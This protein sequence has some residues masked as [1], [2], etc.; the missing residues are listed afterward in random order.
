[1]PDGPI[2]TP[3]EERL[4]RLL[5]E[6]GTPEAAGANLPRR[7]RTRP[8]PG[9]MTTATTYPARPTRAVPGTDLPSGTCYRVVAAGRR[10]GL[11]LHP[12]TRSA[13]P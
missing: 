13:E 9:T 1:M 3:D 11:R 8:P 10:S 2:P 7:T 12:R 4:L 6:S 5:H